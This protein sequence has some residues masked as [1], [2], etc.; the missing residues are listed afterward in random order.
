MFQDIPLASRLPGTRPALANPSTEES[1]S[2]S[3]IAGLWPFSG[4]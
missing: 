1:G 3:E 4:D 2:H